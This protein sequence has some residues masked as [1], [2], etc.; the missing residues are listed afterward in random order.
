M[1]LS[2]EDKAEIQSYMRE[3]AVII[4]EDKILAR[5]PKPEPKEPDPKDGPITPPKKD[6]ADTGKPVKHDRWWGE[7][8]T[9]GG[10]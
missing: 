5:L 9:T 4:R 7:A 6:D 10:E 1:A 3:A 2:P 8:V